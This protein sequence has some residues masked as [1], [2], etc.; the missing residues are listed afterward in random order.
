M[1]KNPHVRICGGPGSATTLVYPTAARRLEQH[2]EI[3]SCDAVVAV[4]PGGLYAQDPSFERETDRDLCG[5]V[6]IH[7]WPSMSL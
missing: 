6:P 3:A 4:T 1:R 5:S 7:V 2:T